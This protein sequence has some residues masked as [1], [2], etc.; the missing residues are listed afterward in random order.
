MGQITATR[1]LVATKVVRHA[2]QWNWCHPCC[3][4]LRWPLLIHFDCVNLTCKIH[5][6]AFRFFSSK[7]YLKYLLT[8]TVNKRKAYCSVTRAIGRQICLIF[9]FA[10]TNT[11]MVYLSLYLIKFYTMYIY[12]ITAFGVFDNAFSNTQS[13]N[14]NL[15]EYSL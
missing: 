10:N 1:N 2:G 13:L 3:N 5:V 6:P 7:Y 4:Q 12:L 9:V 11:N 8:V 14:T 15:Q